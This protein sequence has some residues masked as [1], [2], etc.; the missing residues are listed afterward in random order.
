MSLNDLIRQAR[1][2]IQESPPG[3]LVAGVKE[4]F[5]P[6]AALL[7]ELIMEIRVLRR[8]NVATGTGASDAGPTTEPAPEKEQLSVIL[9][10]IAE[11]V[12]T[13]DSRGGILLMNRVAEELTGWPLKEARGKP[14]N[15]IFWLVDEEQRA[16]NLDPTNLILT[17][18]RKIEA[19]ESLLLINRTGTERLISVVG[20]PVIN[21]NSEMAGVVLV[22]R[23]ITKE[24]KQEAEVLR[25]RRIQSMGILTGGIAHD[26]NNLLTGILGNVNLAK[27]YSE[28]GSKA[29]SRL[30]QAEKACLRAQTL[31][32]Q[33]L[34]FSRSGA[35]VK[36]IIPVADLVT[37]S[38][39]LALRGSAVRYEFQLAEDLWPA[40]IDAGQI[41]QVITN[42]VTNGVQ[43]MPGGGR[44]TIR[45]ENLV[46]GNNQ[47]ALLPLRPGRPYVAIT[48]VD[49]GT[50][51]AP[52]NLGRIF[53]P[54]FT[55]R[56]TGSGLGLATSHAVIKKHEGSLAVESK[57]GQGSSFTCYLPAVP[58]ARE[59]IREAKTGAVPAL[60]AKVLVMDDEELIRGLAMDLLTEAGA[61]TETAGDGQAAIDLY[62]KAMGEGKPFD[63][64]IMDLTVPNGMGGKE[65]VRHL[66]RI[67]PGVKVIVS[68]G[69]STDP[70]MAR[71]QAHGFAG[72]VVKPYTVSTLMETIRE[73]M[74]SEA[75]SRKP[76][77]GSQR[78]ED[79]KK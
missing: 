69:Y 68:S 9:R 71:Y 5:A 63:V 40:R 56:P 77:A 50:G 41:S 49:T 76:E 34:T 13:T 17:N 38:A 28:P 44:L 29:A 42:L 14:A 43:A 54:H 72:K 11:G 2:A 57:P 30:E 15:E 55:T 18:G 75:R 24:K 37:G 23:D 78:T 46:P 58:R 21:R 6:L 25:A 20:A 7:N 53:D 73:V 10:S 39:L 22:F 19:A 12:I 1:L 3:P 74:T 59:A 4:E 65:A 51:I 52:E 60:C 67:D 31:T 8:K 48:I 32:Q 79:R 26:F 45:A 70:T 62:Q 36:K 66:R 27:M 35:P 64:V 33:L 61:E 47:T 16:A